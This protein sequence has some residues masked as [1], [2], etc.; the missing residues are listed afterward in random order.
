MNEFNILEFYDVTIGK[1]TVFTFNY[2]GKLSLA[3]GANLNNYVCVPITEEE[4]DKCTSGDIDTYTLLDNP[5]M[6][7]F[8]F[9]KGSEYVGESRI[10]D[11]ST[12]NNYE[13]CKATFLPERGQYLKKVTKDYSSP[14][15]IIEYLKSLRKKVCAYGSPGNCDCKFIYNEDKLRSGSESGCCE[16]G[17]AIEMLTAKHSPK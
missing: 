13:H 8:Y 6:R 16:L 15:N 12:P 10:I 5:Y 2:K 1:G 7:L 14:E 17:V 11:I 4:L 3:Y 9:S